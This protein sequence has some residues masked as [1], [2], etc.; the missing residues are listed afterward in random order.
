MKQ[1]TIGFDELL[2]FA[3]LF[4]QSGMFPNYSAQGLAVMIQYGTELG[5][6]PYQATQAV[7]VIGKQ[8]ALK[9]EAMKGLCL[10]S[11]K[12]AE[13][14][15]E[16]GGEGDDY[17]ATVHASRN[18]SKTSTVER[19]TIK[20]AKTARLWGRNGPWQ[21]YPDRMLLAR[22]YGYACR[23]VWPD[24]VFG[25]TVEEVQDMSTEQTEAPAA[26]TTPAGLV[27]EPLR[28]PAAMPE[29]LVPIAAGG[30]LDREAVRANLYTWAALDGIGKADARRSAWGVLGFPLNQQL[31]DDRLGQLASW[32]NE[33]QG[34]ASF[35]AIT[36]TFAKGGTA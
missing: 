1:Q 25:Y 12:V 11:G 22:A 16:L 3:D 9:V 13:L 31:D 5:L 2:R 7:A 28:P 4:H 36:N 15:H 32:I 23:D 21:Q 26:T 18:D 19:F 34:A 24:A 27:L 29:P 30:D 17:G 8:P 35:A 20:R 6:G 33:H 14:R 10:A